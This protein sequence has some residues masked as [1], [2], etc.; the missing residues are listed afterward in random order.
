MKRVVQDER[1]ATERRLVLHGQV[2][3]SS[4]EVDE[5]RQEAL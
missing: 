4:Q 3:R 2:Q 5:L 1:A